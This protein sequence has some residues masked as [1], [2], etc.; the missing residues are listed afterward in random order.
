MINKRISN[1]SSN[2][3]PKNHSAF[4][5]QLYSYI[6]RFQ[7]LLHLSI[8]SDRLKLR[9]KSLANCILASFDDH[10]LIDKFL[11]LPLITMV[12][13]KAGLINTKKFML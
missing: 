2:Q 3:N 1:I 5:I 8:K 7:R 10:L 6:V 11:F 9:H 12:T 13:A 4:N